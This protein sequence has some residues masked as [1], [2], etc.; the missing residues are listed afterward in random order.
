MRVSTVSVSYGRTV[1]L[2]NFNSLRY[3]ATV[4]VQIDEGEDCQT[5]LSKARATAKQE[6]EKAVLGELTNIEAG[7][8]AIFASMKGNTK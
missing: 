1:N 8:D 4:E 6:V 2:G 3:D 7:R 5:A